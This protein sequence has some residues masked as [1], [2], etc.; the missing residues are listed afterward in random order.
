MKTPSSNPDPNKKPESPDD[1]AEKGKKSERT[2]WAPMPPIGGPMI[3][4]GRVPMQSEVEDPDEGFD[5]QRDSN[6]RI[7]GLIAGVTAASALALVVLTSRNPEERISTA[8]I[9]DLSS[10]Q[11][12]KKPLKIKLKCDNEALPIACSIPKNCRMDDAPVAGH[13]SFSCPVQGSDIKW[14]TFSTVSKVED[15][16]PRGKD[17]D[18]EFQSA[19]DVD[20]KP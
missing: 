5:P 8:S 15:M 12:L 10:S 20:K 13:V 9:P 1:S 18:I 4:L 19:P 7:F 6:R 11:E 3:N 17:V 2:Y 16:A 14:I